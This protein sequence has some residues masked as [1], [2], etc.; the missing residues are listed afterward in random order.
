MRRGDQLARR[1]QRTSVGPSRPCRRHAVRLVQDHDPASDDA[2]VKPGVAVGRPP[3]KQ[4]VQFARARSAACP[5][6]RAFPFAGPA[7]DFRSRAR[8]SGTAGKLAVVTVEPSFEADPPLTILFD[9]LLIESSGVRVGG[10]FHETPPNSS[11]RTRDRLCRAVVGS[12]GAGPDRATSA[13]RLPR[14]ACL[15]RQAIKRDE[16]ARRRRPGVG[17]RDDLHNRS[18]PSRP[19][20]PPS[21]VD[22]PHRRR[23]YAAGR[24]PP[25]REAPGIRQLERGERIAR[26]YITLGDGRQLHRIRQP[27]GVREFGGERVRHRGLDDEESANQDEAQGTR[28]NFHRCSPSKRTRN[29]QP[30]AAGHHSS[31]HAGAQI[32]GRKCRSS[33]QPSVKLLNSK[34]GYEINVRQNDLPRRIGA[35]L[36]AHRPNP[37]PSCLQLRS[38]G[39]RLTVFTVSRGKSLSCPGS[40]FRPVALRAAGARSMMIEVTPAANAFGDLAGGDQRLE[41]AM[42]DESSSGL[43]GAS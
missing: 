23:S 34:V 5:T 33:Q 14:Q 35:P 7:P 30:F 42:N 19:F 29:R 37:N 2:N 38:G 9:R 15:I 31:H 1:G 11:A 39:L 16:A 27:A 40:H 22:N 26:Q 41:A 4:V 6:A 21:P 17:D 43:H 25:S 18:I 3:S 12:S 24:R 20:P 36:N 28:D 8:A 10:C 13:R 32:I